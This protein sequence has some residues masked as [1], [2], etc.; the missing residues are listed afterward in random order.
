MRD[1]ADGSSQT[2]AVGER[3][4]TSRGFR[5]AIWMRAVNRN[6][7]SIYGAPVAGTCDRRVLLNSRQSRIIG[8]SSLHTGGA[9]FLLAD[10]AVRF[11]GENI[12]YKLYTSLARISDGGPRG[13][14]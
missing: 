11:I 8:F 4:M 2:F 10:G 9:H 6:G 3:E 7:T 12:D 13:A 14:F 5:G 1:I